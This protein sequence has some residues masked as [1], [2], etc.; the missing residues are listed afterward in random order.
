MD[1]T[2]S[3]F[4]VALIINRGL[5]PSEQTELES[6]AGT[7]QGLKHQPALAPVSHPPAAC[8]CTPSHTGSA[9]FLLSWSRGGWR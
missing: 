6:G 4:F 8:P 5:A 9:V 3:L 7:Q 1:V 2:V